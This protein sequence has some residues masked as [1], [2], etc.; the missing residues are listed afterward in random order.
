MASLGGRGEARAGQ[1]RGGKGEEAWQ[2]VDFPPVQVHNCTVALCTGM[3]KGLH[4]FG[5][6][7]Y[8][9]PSARQKPEFFQVAVLKCKP[10]STE[11]EAL[12]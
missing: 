4:V 6:L 12:R 10:L 2:Q 11:Y 3:P 5:R 9:W 1:G 7:G 8:C